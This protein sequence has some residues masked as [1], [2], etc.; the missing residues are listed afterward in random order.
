MNTDDE[1]M[2]LMA[3]YPQPPMQ[4]GM[5]QPMQAPMGAPMGGAMGGGG[6]VS[7]ELV[8]AILGLQG[9]GPQQAEIARSRRLADMLRADAGGQM[10]GIQ[11]GR[12]YA[13]PGLANVAA[14]LYG[15]Y[16]AK[17]MDDDAD[18]RTRNL[19]VQSQDAMRRYFEAMAGRKGA[20]M[21]M[22]PHMGDEGE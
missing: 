10:Q 19:S 22:L 17:R 15:Q 16:K 11:A 9:Q 7:P 4:A 13:A 6:Q 18:T 20:G 3:R 14:S 21:P 8:Q 5:Q 12:M 2:R 1:L